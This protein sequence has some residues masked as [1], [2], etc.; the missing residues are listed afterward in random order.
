VNF[1]QGGGQRTKKGRKKDQAL[2]GLYESL[3]GKIR[4]TYLKGALNEQSPIFSCTTFSN[5]K[6]IFKTI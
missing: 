6:I 1:P 4:L 5:D 3:V 2:L